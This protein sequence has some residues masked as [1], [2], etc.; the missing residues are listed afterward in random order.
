M[1]Q[2]H[3]LPGWTDLFAPDAQASAG[4]YTTLFGWDII[5]SGLPAPGAYYMFQHQGRSVA[6]VG[7]VPA[8]TRVPLG[9]T[10]CILVDDVDAI[11]ARASG[12]GAEVMLPSADVMAEGRV[13]VVNDPTGAAVGFWQGRDHTG[14]DAFCEPGLICW[15]ELATSDAAAAARFYTALLPWEAQI[16][17]MAAGRSY[18]TLSMGG[19]SI[20]G[21]FTMGGQWPPGTRPHWITYFAVADTGETMA[22]AKD[23]GGSVRGEAYHTPF[24]RVATIADP[25]GA[26]FGVITL[27]QA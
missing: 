27:S 8:G 4:F 7:E 3:G 17:N 5:D 10:T 21:C 18:T 23:L 20:G 19:E 11:E 14:A 12:L 26:R 1:G 24:G 2:R 25:D 9:W 16:E 6:G 22:V 15:N 13:L